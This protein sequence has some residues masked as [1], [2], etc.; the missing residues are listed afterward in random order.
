M[1]KSQ[2]KG[3]TA[4]KMV[5]MLQKHEKRNERFDKEK[6]TTYQQSRK[7]DQEVENHRQKTRMKQTL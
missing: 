1:A 4:E 3:T 6:E 2:I 7:N 5:E